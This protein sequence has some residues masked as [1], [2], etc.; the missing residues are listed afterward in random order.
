MGS[1]QHAR[2]NF[3]GRGWVVLLVVDIGCVI[4]GTPELSMPI[5]QHARFVAR[6]IVSIPVSSI[7]NVQH[8][9][10]AHLG[11]SIPDFGTP[12]F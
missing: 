8:C 6:L 12:W 9:Y 1:I 7:H 5:I 4:I 2:G 3:R 11:F 10:A